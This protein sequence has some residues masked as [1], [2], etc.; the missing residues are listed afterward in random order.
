MSIN[1]LS[2]HRFMIF[3]AHTI[4]FERLRPL[5]N[6]VKPDCYHP[7]SVSFEHVRWYKVQ[8]STYLLIPGILL[9]GLISL[10]EYRSDLPG[11]RPSKI[12]SGLFPPELSTFENIFSQGVPVVSKESSNTL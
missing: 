2:K 6:F 12:E 3:H 1:D 7:A 9:P 10:E 11:Y 8:F 4:R 5:L